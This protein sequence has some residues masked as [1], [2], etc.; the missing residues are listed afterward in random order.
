MLSGSRKI[1][2]M[3]TEDVERISKFV[4]E[5]VLENRDNSNIL[6]ITVLFANK[7][8]LYNQAS[9]I[10]W[11]VSLHKGNDLRYI[12]INSE[13]SF[14]VCENYADMMKSSHVFFDTLSCEYVS[15]ASGSNWQS[16]SS[17]ELDM[18]QQLRVI[19]DD[20]VNKLEV[21]V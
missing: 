3:S 2:R 12:L 10:G 1:V 7:S 14:Q 20:L 11:Y 13:W 9:C 21:V 16:I 5:F 18:K 17:G 19:K 15:F 6:N 8:V 4:R